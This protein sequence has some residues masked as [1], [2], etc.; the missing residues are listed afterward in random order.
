M[1]SELNSSSSSIYLESSFIVKVKEIISDEES[2]KEK[3][4]TNSYLVQAYN[5]TDVEVLIAKHYRNLNINYQ[6]TSMTK[7]KMKEVLLS[8]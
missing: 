3:S 4:I 2:P 5:P 1:S 8:N 7:S 6:I